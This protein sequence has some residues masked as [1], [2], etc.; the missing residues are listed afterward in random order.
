MAGPAGDASEPSGLT[1]GDPS[2]APSAGPPADSTGEQGAG[3]NA[4][5]RHGRPGQFDLII[6]RRTHLQPRFV[7]TRRRVRRRG[8]SDG[9]RPHKAVEPLDLADDLPLPRFVGPKHNEVARRFAGLRIEIGPAR[10]RAAGEHRGMDDGGDEGAVGARVR[11]AEMQTAR[12]HE[13]R[14]PRFDGL[15]MPVD[16]IPHRA[17][18]REDELEIGVPVAGRGVAVAP[19]IVAE[20]VERQPGHVVVHALRHVGEHLKLLDHAASPLIAIIN[21]GRSRYH[22]VHYRNAKGLAKSYNWYRKQP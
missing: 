9:A 7:R 13:N 18:Q 8:R 14:M 19:Q 21:C 6:R 2:A 1:A 4:A 10:F 11:I 20:R 22:L 3:R 12:V 16:R 5:G 15:H 17:G